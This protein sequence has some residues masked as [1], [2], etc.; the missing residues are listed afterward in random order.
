[1]IV[2]GSLIHLDMTMR[3]G[4]PPHF[5]WEKAGGGYSRIIRGEVCE[6]TGKSRGV[7]I[8]PGFEKEVGT[9]LRLSDDL[10]EVYSKIN[11]DRH[12]DYSIRK[13]RG[14]RMTLSD[15]WEAIV[16]YVCSANNNI[17]R[18]SKN[19]KGLMEEGRILSADE[20]KNK[21]LSSLRRGY[22]EKYLKELSDEIQSINLNELARQSYEEK[23]EYLASLPGVGE[24]VSE[25]VL[26]FGFGHLDAFPVDVW[27]RKAM[28]EYYGIEKPKEAR[29]FASQKWKGYSGYAQQYLFCQ[30]R[31]SKLK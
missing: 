2:K 8:T 5:T 18:I 6:I 23:K 29:E 27:V 21:N 16:C 13:L 14:M 4:Q 24:K 7:G 12:M 31:E 3:S 11:T 15:P 25:C 28:K 1:M 30:A 26:L 17:P 10:E 20:I 19:V 22:R 9:L